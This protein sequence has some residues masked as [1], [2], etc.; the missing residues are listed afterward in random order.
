M[1]KKEEK[2]TQR[3]RKRPREDRSGDWKYEATS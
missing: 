2:K 1:K 3:Q